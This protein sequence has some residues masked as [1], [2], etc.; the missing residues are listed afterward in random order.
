M[1]VSTLQLH[2]IF[3]KGREDLISSLF[4]EWIFEYDFVEGTFTTLNGEPETYGIRIRR[5]ESGD[6]IDMNVICPD[7]VEAFSKCCEEWEPEAPGDRERHSLDFRVKNGE[8]WKWLNI[9]CVASEFFEGSAVAIT[10]KVSDIDSEKRERIKLTD[11]AQRDSLTGLFNREA[12]ETR[13]K[14]VLEDVNNGDRDSFAVM[15]IDIDNFKGI[16]DNYGHLFGDLSIIDMAGLLRTKVFPTDI[17]G[18]FGGDEFI[19]ACTDYKTVNELEDRIVTLRRDYSETMH[20]EYDG[21]SFSCSIGVAF[22]G[23]DGT[24]YETLVS[25]ADKALYYVKEHGKDNYKFC[26]DQVKEYFAS[27]NAAGTNQ[28]PI[29]DN[30]NLTDELVHYTLDLFEAS[31]DM[32]EAAGVLLGRIG[33]RFSLS[34]VSLRE[35]EQNGGST[36]KYVWFDKSAPDN[37]KDESAIS[38][39]DKNACDRV[40]NSGETMIIRSIT[41]MVDGA[42]VKTMMKLEGISAFVKV[43]LISSNESFGCIL[44][45]TINGDRD[46]TEEEL[47]AFFTMSRILSV[48][49]VRQ[50][51]YD[52]IQRQIENMLSYDELTGL[53]K[54]EKFK[55]IAGRVIDE[56]K[57]STYAVIAAD[58][59]K[60]K[61][62]NEHYGFKT[63]DEFIKDFA[64]L[65]VKHNPR[66][67][68][69]CRKYAD[70]FVALIRVERPELLQTT[71]EGYV[72]RFRQNE[73]IKFPDFD[74]EV[75]L[76]FYLFEAERREIGYGL[77]NAA[78]AKRALKEAGTPGVKQYLPEMKETKIREVAFLHTLEEAIDNRE[79][80]PFL[81]PK[82]DLKTGEIDGAE[83]LVRWLKAD[84]TVGM[85]DEYIPLLEKSGKIIELDYL[86]FENVLRML[87]RWKT[88]G[89]N[90]IPISVNFSRKHVKNDMFVS[91]LLR[92]TDYFGIDRKLI[93]IEITESA[94]VDDHN[95]LIKVMNE[96]KKQGFMLAVDDFGKG[97]SSLSML[98]E[99]PADI[100]KIDREFLK[101]ID[102]GPGR[103][104]L[105]NVIHLIKDTKKRVVCEG[106]EK[107]DEA[108]LLREFGCEV[109]Q[110][111]LYG[112]P[113]AIADFEKRFNNPMQSKIS[114]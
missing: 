66:L 43:P 89:R 74:P 34:F 46:W 59:S 69:G 94:F 15:I 73:A 104:M 102:D 16:N 2:S 37:Y 90:I 111:F 20:L 77:D 71:L 12:F 55:E 108:K 103:A 58:I 95:A 35:K 27:R 22:Y 67:V 86:V 41:E 114:E 28:T 109:G 9:T 113:M 48:Y 11:K 17:V 39:A 85:P 31:E 45:G 76:G 64:T 25:N 4:D 62:F 49:L 91:Y 38:L 54:Y 47:K 32:M 42:P 23:D 57:D 80:V 19:V 61:F 60:F 105:E 3:E 29:A 75:N 10:A 96:I 101:N 84:N 1:A 63:G 106:I 88:E 14:K 50:K 72:N 36:V 5:S 18:R 24:D 13:I 6:R 79:F 99:V 56:D 92:Q 97:Y 78:F 87:Q 33:R 21:A 26:D 40:F 52:R 70:S 107:Q 100:I 112:K 65:I 82:V 98:N 30:T 51:D 53:L 83:A 8:D 93:E 7:D 68:A 44:F 110:G 81:Q